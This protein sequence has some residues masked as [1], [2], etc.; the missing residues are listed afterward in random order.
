MNLTKISVTNAILM[1]S[2]AFE[3]EPSLLVEAIKENNLKEQFME[4][5]AGNLSFADF[6]ELLDEVF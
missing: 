1:I 2:G 5:C 3:V 4:F 6:A